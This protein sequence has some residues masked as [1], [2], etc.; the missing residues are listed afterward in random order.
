MMHVA[1]VVKEK[2]IKQNKIRVQSWKHRCDVDVNYKTITKMWMQ[3]CRLGQVCE[4]GFS[5]ECGLE[6]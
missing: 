5:V 1:N 2:K 6:G 4:P 3:Q